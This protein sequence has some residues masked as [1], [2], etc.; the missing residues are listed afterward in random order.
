VNVAYPGQTIYNPGLK[1]R[2]TFLKTAADS[3][4]ELLSFEDAVAPGN[5]GPPKH[6]HPQQEEYFEVR[7]GRVEIE[8]DKETREMGPG[9]SATVPPG[10]AHTF[11]VI[12]DEEAM[13]LTEFRPAGDV[14]GWLESIFALPDQG[15][16]RADGSPKLLAVLPIAQKHLDDFVLAGPP[17]IAQRILLSIVSPIARLLGNRSDYRAEAPAS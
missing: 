4:G 8:L 14:E 12:G 17:L 15:K 10:L 7:R 9:D 2:I 5:P 11:R 13:M 16:V 6:Y 3:G 1:E